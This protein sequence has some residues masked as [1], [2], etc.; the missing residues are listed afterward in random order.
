MGLP[1]A[2]SALAFWHCSGLRLVFLLSSADP[3]LPT[4]FPPAR[5]LLGCAGFAL[6]GLLLEPRQPQPPL[7]PGLGLGHA[8]HQQQQQQ[9]QPQELRQQHHLTVELLAA[10]QVLLSAV[11]ES[12]EL[13]EEVLRWVKGR[14]SFL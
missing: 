14:E 6:V 8:N 3:V 7:D 12:Q 4:F 9:Q 2:S 11:S 13:A 5:L 1:S 10:M